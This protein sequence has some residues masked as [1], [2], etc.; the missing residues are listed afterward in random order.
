MGMIIF[1]YM[2]YLATIVPESLAVEIVEIAISA[3]VEGSDE[4][5]DP[6]IGA[7]YF[8]AIE[9]AALKFGRRGFGIFNNNFDFLI[10]RNGQGLGRELMVLERQYVIIA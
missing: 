8:L 4:N 5:R 10:G 3:R 7:D 2:N 6:V 9:I 1:P